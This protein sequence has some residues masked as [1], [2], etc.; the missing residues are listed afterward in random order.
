MSE[1]RPDFARRFRDLA[2]G[3]CILAVAAWM[4]FFVKQLYFPPTPDLPDP[5]DVP[6]F[7]EES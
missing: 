2:V 4:W 5:P 3:A 6:S 7:W 1:P